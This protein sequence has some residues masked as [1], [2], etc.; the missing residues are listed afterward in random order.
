MKKLFLAIGICAVFG[1]SL[2][3]FA[4]TY[5]FTDS[6]TFESWY[7]P[8]VDRMSSMGVIKGYPDGAFKPKNSVTRAELAVM[9]DRLEQNMTGNTTD[10]VSEAELNQKLDAL[11]QKLTRSSGAGTSDDEIENAI[12]YSLLAYD[13]FSS[14]NIDRTFKV[15]LV[16]AEAGMKKLSSKPDMTNITKVTDVQMPEGYTLYEE[17]HIVY[18]YYLNYVGQRT[19]GDVIMNVN[20]WYGPFATY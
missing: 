17:P 14:L 19:D 3:A 5:Y 18:S 13:K 20:E 4:A 12:Q 2:T 7:A 1:I 16:M 9:L 15:Y 11:E 10:G 6:F 8:S